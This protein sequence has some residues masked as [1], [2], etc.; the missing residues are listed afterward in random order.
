MTEK[1][2]EILKDDE[3]KVILVDRADQPS[4]T[5]D[6]LSAHKHGHLHRAFSVILYNSEGEMLIQR[7]ALSKYHSPGLW[8]NT[9]CGHPLPHESAKEAAQRRLREEIGFTCDLN[10]RTCILYFLRLE[11]QMIEHEYVHVFEA[12]VPSDTLFKLNP[13]EVK[14]VSWMLPHQGQKEAKQNPHLYTRWFRLYLLKYFAKV[15]K[16]KLD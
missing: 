13:D 4:G 9:C 1:D 2:S 11:H 6:K 8:A 7:R 14:G 12:E 15:F 5:E 10:F 16:Q 3:I